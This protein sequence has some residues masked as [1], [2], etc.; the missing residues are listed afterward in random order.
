MDLSS[1]LPFLCIFKMF[2]SFPCRCCIFQNENAFPPEVI[3]HNVFLNKE[4]NLKKNTDIDFGCCLHF[5]NQE[6]DLTKLQC[7]DSY[8]KIKFIN[9]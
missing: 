8:L 9:Y 5:E 4:P 3:K 7:R 2:V 1:L 6:R